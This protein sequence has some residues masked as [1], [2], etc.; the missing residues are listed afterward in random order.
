MAF[1]EEKAMTDNKDLTP[2]KAG[3]TYTDWWPVFLESLRNM[4]N[5]ARACRAAGISRQTAYKHKHD[6]NEFA[7]AWEDA[8]QDGLDKWEEEM[9]RRAFEGNDV[10]VMYE[11]QVVQWRKDFSDTLAIVLMKAHRPEKYRERSEVRQDGE[12]IIKVKYE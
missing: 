4:P 5:V 11:G 10:P 12:L 9:A 6:F 1:E 7:K 8:L 2:E 3:Q